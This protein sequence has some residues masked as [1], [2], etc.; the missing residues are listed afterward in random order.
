MNATSHTKLRPLA[1]S[2]LA[3]AAL[4]AG[5]GG[6]DGPPAQPLACADLSG[7]AIPASAIG[8]PTSGGTVTTATMVAA[9]GTGAAAVPEHC[10]VSASISPVD[11]TAPK[12][13]L[14]VALPGTW[15]SKVLMYGGGG[16]DGSIPN[17]AGNVPAGPTDAPLPLARGYAVFASDSGHQAG[18]RGSLDG[19]FGLNDEALRN[20]GGDALKKTRDAAVFLVKA[21]YAGNPAKAYFAG[22]STGGREALQSIQRWPNDW[23]GAIAWYPAWN[24]ASAM[25]G[26]Q[27]ASITLARPGAYPNGAKRLAV[28]QA[29]MQACDGLDG[30]TD[31]L[32]ANQAACNASFDPATA[33]VNGAPLRCAGGADTADTCLSDVQIDALKTMNAPVKFGFTLTSGETGYPGYNIWGADLGI[34]SFTAA[35]QPTI[36]FLNLG[37]SQPAN[38]MPATAPYISQQLDQVLKNIITRDQAFDPLT[39][40]PTLPNAALAPRWGLLSSMIDQST[41]ISGFAAR[42][43]KLLL[44]HGLHDALVSSRAT[45]DYYGRLRQRFGAATADSFIR[46]YEVA[47]FGHAFSSQFN[48]TW[49]SLTA[50]EQWAEKGAAPSGQITRDTVGVPGRTRPLCDHPTWPRYKGTGDV[51]VA[52]SYN[53][54][55]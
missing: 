32:I 22:G 43:G 10:L 34:P 35:I 36:T 11:A 31:G 45:A 16:F 41:D 25:L 1:W 29:A 26:G 51:N 49:D 39:F 55:N 17:V 38:P 53:C 37:S 15:N 23:D 7:M 21:R 46:Y 2:G 52:S 5:C 3:T 44:A 9:S 27:K 24:Q 33:M 30:V 6:D 14:R 4:L 20:W 19:S 42:G 18:A 54:V 12:I 48:A 40:D 47:G 28:F 50:L 13:L 8:L